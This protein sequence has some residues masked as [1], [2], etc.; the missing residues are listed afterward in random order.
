[1]PTTPLPHSAYHTTEQILT[2]S[3]SSSSSTISYPDVPFGV[4]LESIAMLDWQILSGEGQYD[5]LQRAQLP[6]SSDGNDGDEEDAQN[7]E[8]R[9]QCNCIEN[10]PAARQPGASKPLGAYNRYV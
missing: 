7:A 8:A 6:R 2:S 1:M 9:F 10:K 4:K 5:I 3:S